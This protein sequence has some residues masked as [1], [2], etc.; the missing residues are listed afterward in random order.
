[1]AFLDED[2]NITGRLIVGGA[3]VVGGRFLGANLLIP[4]LASALAFFAVGKIRPAYANASRLALAIL[5]GHAAWMAVGAIVMPSMREQVMLD[6]VAAFCL[7]AVL[8]WRMSKPAMIALIFI[9][10]T[11][12]AI[13]VFLLVTSAEGAVIGAL[14]A[15]ILIRSLIIFYILQAWITGTSKAMSDED[16]VDAFN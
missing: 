7:F 14:V 8:L 10:A 1:M 15:H 3:A 13:N 6:V 11:S 2:N 4:V 12:L 5:F 9:E 16:L